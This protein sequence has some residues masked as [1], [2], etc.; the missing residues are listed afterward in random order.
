[1]KKNVVY[2]E[3]TEDHHVVKNNRNYAKHFPA[4][5]IATRTLCAVSMRKTKHKLRGYRIFVIRTLY[6]EAYLF[7]INSPK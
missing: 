3:K 5:D 6:F 2:Q 7:Q 4:R 1:M